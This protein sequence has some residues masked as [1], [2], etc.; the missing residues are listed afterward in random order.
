[1]QMRDGTEDEG[2]EVERMSMHYDDDQGHG[3]GHLNDDDDGFLKIPKKYREG[4]VRGPIVGE[5]TEWTPEKIAY[6]ERLADQVG[7]PSC[8]RYWR[9][10]DE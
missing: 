4:L 6:A 7:L 10:E 9:K 5:A 1:M 8:A 3:L 2:L